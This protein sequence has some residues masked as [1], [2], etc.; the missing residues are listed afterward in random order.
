MIMCKACDDFNCLGVSC[1]ILD[2][3]DLGQL[4]SFALAV[5]WIP[6]VLTSARDIVR[7]IAEACVLDTY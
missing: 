3:R 4:A 5:N 1:G 6:V 2:R 7:D